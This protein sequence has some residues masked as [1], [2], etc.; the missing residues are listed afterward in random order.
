MNSPSLKHEGWLY[1]LAFLIAIALR[2]IALGASPLTD[3]EATLA[4]QSLALARGESPLLEPQSAYILFTAV[5]FDI[6]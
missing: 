6:M 4:L 5:L 3:S 1:G 2:F